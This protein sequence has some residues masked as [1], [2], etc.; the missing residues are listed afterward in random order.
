MV[1][2]TDRPILLCTVDYPLFTVKVL[3]ERHIIVAGGGGESNTGV[4]NYA[5]IF[6]LVYDPEVDTCRAVPVARLNTG[7]YLFFMFHS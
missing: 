4:R 5:D 6:E 7:L 3:S 1:N 2:S